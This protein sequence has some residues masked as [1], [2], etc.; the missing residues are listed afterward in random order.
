M[1]TGFKDIVAPVYEVVTPQT[2]LRYTL[3]SLDVGEEE[4]LKGS[5]LS[6]GKVA[7]HLNK[8][9]FKVLV[10][11]PDVVTDY[12]SFLSHTTIKDRDA[13]LFGLYHVTYEEIRNY[14]VK[15][16]GCQKE[17]KVTV[18]A[19][20][21]FN[22]KSYPNDNICD[23]EIEVPLPSTRGVTACIKQPT[24]VDENRIYN[25][26]NTAIYPIGIALQTVAISKIKQDILESKTPIIWDDR[27]DIIDAYTALKPKDKRAI[28]DAYT[29]SF[30]QY[31][32]E[33]HMRYSCQFCGL[34]DDVEVDLVDNFF[35]MVLSA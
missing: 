11:K 24:L 22:F 25:S 31:C 8:C 26:V 9:I 12:A 6:S 16:S 29:E 19:S 32:I 28:V 15:C 2:H 5:L 21:M 10:D 23:L 13:L 30:G 33:L 3:R 4:Q 1:F 20:D 34:S 35:R 14:V 18:K 17:S 27:N 7:D